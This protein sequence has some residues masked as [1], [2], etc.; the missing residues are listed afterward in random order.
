M[1]SADSQSILQCSSSLIDGSRGK[2]QLLAENFSTSYFSWDTP[3]EGTIT[4]AVSC[5]TDRISA[6]DIAVLPTLQ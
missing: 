4:S 3:V 6:H 1:L 2:S 5:P